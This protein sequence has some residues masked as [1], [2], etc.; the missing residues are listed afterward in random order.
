MDTTVEKLGPSNNYL[1][2]F[3]AYFNGGS[4]S[5]LSPA[6]IGGIVAG[7]IGFILIVVLIAVLVYCCRLRHPKYHSAYNTDEDQGNRAQT[8]E[9]ALQQK[10]IRHPDVKP[11]LYI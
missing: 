6:A 2:A 9:H 7:I 10:L 1:T 4:G 5:V 11:E 8:A 3:S